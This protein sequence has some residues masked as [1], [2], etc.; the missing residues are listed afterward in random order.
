MQPVLRIYSGQ[1]AL[2]SS[3]GFHCEVIELNMHAP[4]DGADRSEA[5][6]WHESK[7]LQVPKQLLAVDGCARGA[8]PRDRQLHCVPDVG[9]QRFWEEARAQDPIRGRYIRC[10]VPY[11]KL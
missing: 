8:I 6:V 10:G 4:S 7:R 1:R 5:V 9:L 11:R 2:S 3:S